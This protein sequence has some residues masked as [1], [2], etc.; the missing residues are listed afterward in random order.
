MS[1]SYT[2]RIGNGFDIH[3]LADGDGITLGGVLIPFHKRL[4]GHSDAD[5]L[6]HAIMDAL[7]GAAGLPDI[8]VLFPNTDPKYKGASSMHL[9]EEVMRSIEGAGFT[10]ENL[11]TVLLAE[12]PKIS[13]FRDLMKEQIS[14]KLKIKSDAVGIKATTME[15]LGSIGRGEGIAASATVLLKKAI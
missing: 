10:V 2:Y 5:V 7:L 8:G 6:V 1:G 9:L 12:A 3:P 14:Q 11:D 15:K 4:V 13:P